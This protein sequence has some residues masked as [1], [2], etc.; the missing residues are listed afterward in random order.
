[1]IEFIKGCELTGWEAVAVATLFVGAVFFLV[2][3]LPEVTIM[4]GLIAFLIITSVGC[5]SMEWQVPIRLE[6]EYKACTA[7]AVTHALSTFNEG[8][9]A[10]VASA[11]FDNPRVYKLSAVVN[12]AVDMGLCGGYVP[13]ESVECLKLAL[14]HSVVVLTIPFYESMNELD[15]FGCWTI[16][17]APVQVGRHTVLVT[18]YER[19]MFTVLNSWGWRWGS[20]GR[21]FV[22]ED[23]MEKLFEGGA[24]GV[25]LME[26]E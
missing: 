7:T 23:Q 4:L 12:K 1:M 10:E 18:C 16:A 25:V 24:H 13:I 9:D 6:Q 20:N 2:K 5:A 21:C 17:D 14:E 26:V 15:R 11:L 8:M 3:R 22:W 19:Q